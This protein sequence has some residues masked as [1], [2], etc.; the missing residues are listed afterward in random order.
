MYWYARHGYMKYAG[1]PSLTK[2]RKKAMRYMESLPF[3]AD[4]YIYDR[5]ATKSPIGKVCKYGD[6]YYWV[7]ETG[8]YV[9]KDDG[10][11][12]IRKARK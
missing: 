7:T 8:M 10:S 12:K 1:Y 11:R 9:L 3:K 2:T 5:E 6:V 4:V